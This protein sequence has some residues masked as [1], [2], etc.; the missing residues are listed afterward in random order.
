MR[1]NFCLIP[2][3]KSYARPR[4]Y[5]LKH[6]NQQPYSLSQAC[7]VLYQT[8]SKLISQKLFKLYQNISEEGYWESYLESILTV[9][10]EVHTIKEIALSDKRIGSL[11][12]Q[13]LANMVHFGSKT[14]DAHC[15][16]TIA[17]SLKKI[18]KKE[19]LIKIDLYYYNF[20]LSWKL[21]F[22]FNFGN[23]LTI[24]GLFL[25]IWSILGRKLRMLSSSRS[26]P[27]LRGANWMNRL[28]T[29]YL[30]A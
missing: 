26:K 28:S 29:T 1:P 23:F 9:N 5:I 10:V 3:G 12:H 19:L 27:F 22:F 7:S 18:I 15:G 16:V 17:W 13:T 11:T 21:F 20:C 8:V 24:F 25:P 2:K 6:P 14:E 30:Q 4:L